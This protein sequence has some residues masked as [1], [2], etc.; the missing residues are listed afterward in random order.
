[1]NMILPTASISA[2][3][4]GTTRPQVRIVIVGHVDHGKST[5][6]GRLLHET[7]SLPDGKLEMLKAVSARRGMPFEWS[8]LLDALQTERDQ[9][10]TIDTTQIRFRT[11]S[12]DVVLIDAPG[13]AE[14]LRNMITGASQADGAVLIID[15][16]EGVRDQTR[17][18]G[19]LLHL[20]GVKQVAVVVNKMDR[21]EFS[22][23]RF[24]E[25]SDEISAHLIGLG[26]TPTAVIPISARDGDGVAE[27]TARIDWYQGPTVV[28]ALDALEPARPL[29]EL[30]LRLPV[31]AIYKFDDRRIV[32]GRIESGSLKAGDEIVIMPTGKIAQIKT[33]ESW[34]VTP[35]TAPQGAGRSVGITLDRELFLERG[36]I[37][38]HS[39]QSPRDT[40][41]I[42]ARIFWLHDKP[43][44]KGEQILIRL[45]TKESRATV[46][47]I[48]KAIDPGALSNEENTAIARNHVGE[49]DI[50]LAQPVATDPYTDNPR[51]GRLVIEVNGRIAGGGLV[52]SV[53]AGRPAVPVDIVPVESAL[54]PDERSARY[55]H[56][57][58]VIWLTGL[59]GSGKSTLARAL[60][61]RLFSNGGSPIL[62]DGDTLRAGLNGDLGFSPQDRAENIRRLA[63]VATHLARNGHIAIVAA[64]SPS[65]ADRAAARRIAD[66]AFRE[67]YVATP[68]EVCETRDPKGH[69]A[70]ARSGGLPSFT[71]ITN[72][73]QPPTG[74]ELTIDTSNRSVSDATD[75]IE[76]M[77]ATTG[78]LFDELTDLAANI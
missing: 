10:I 43:L 20:L 24:K 67:I 6:V 3:P 29:A 8:F 17:R 27:R 46:V 57:G 18:H 9:G 76:R 53:D 74:N 50:S 55:H 28:E 36:D 72:D 1:M 45:G 70:K 44:T 4:N 40:R 41:R 78:I 51:T 30:P 58:A 60:E 65:T 26:V 25:I 34:P 33:V 35:V 23:D 2:T 56:N 19:Y 71:G 39:G 52:L 59:P 63:E 69:Y 15:A 22:A 68:A 14:F 73:Y 32:A 16:L 48:E 5:L 21:V 64:V 38:G 75:E 77:L 31:Q 11:R 37:I 62:L 7:G 54:R 47:A 13:H 61:R 66:S 42:R 49:I 12:R